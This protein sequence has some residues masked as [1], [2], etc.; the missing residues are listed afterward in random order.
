MTC[1]HSSNATHLDCHMGNSTSFSQKSRG[2]L[3]SNFIW[4]IILIVLGHLNKMAAPPNI[5]KN[6]ICFN[7]KPK[8]AFTYFNII[9]EIKWGLQDLLVL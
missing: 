7:D 6:K 3:N 4:S 9:K 1:E 8:L 5:C 2:C